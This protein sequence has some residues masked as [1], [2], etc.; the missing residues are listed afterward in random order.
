[1]NTILY[2]LLLPLR[3]LF[4][5]IRSSEDLNASHP[6][7]IALDKGWLY[8]KYGTLTLFIALNLALVSGVPHVRLSSTVH[9]SRIGE[10]QGKSEYIGPFGFKA[11]DAAET[12]PIPPRIA[13][14][15]I[16]Q[17]FWQ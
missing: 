3:M 14:I 6:L 15:P 10:L 12:G 9:T 17:I 8:C 16:H 4:R 13:F 7:R 11:I 1:M 5:F 2:F